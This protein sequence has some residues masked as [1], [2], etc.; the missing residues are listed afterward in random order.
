[1]LADDSAVLTSVLSGRDDWIWQFSPD[2]FDNINRMPTLQAVRADSMRV[3]Y[4][5]MDAAGRWDVLAMP[6]VAGAITPP[7]L[8]MLP[9]IIFRWC[10]AITA[11]SELV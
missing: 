7:D 4:L 10:E 9:S 5:S 8:P 1:M 11:S 2:Q 3:G 6:A